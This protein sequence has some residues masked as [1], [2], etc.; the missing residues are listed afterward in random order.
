MSRKATS[1]RSAVLQKRS[2]SFSGNLAWNEHQIALL[3]TAP[4]TAIEMRLGIN[5]SSVL[6]KRTSLGIPAFGHSTS[7]KKYHTFYEEH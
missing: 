1:A 6:P 4:D 5:S 7:E 2:Q 3:G